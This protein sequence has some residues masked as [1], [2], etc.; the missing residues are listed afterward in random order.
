MTDIASK[1]A[2]ALTILAGFE[3][4][5]GRANISDAGEARM[6]ACLTL[7][8]FEQFRSAMCLIDNGLGTHAAGPIRS[9]LEGVADLVNLAK[10]PNYLSQ[11]HYD[12]ARSNVALYDDA[13]GLENVPPHISEFLREKRD[14]DEPVRKELREAGVG[15]LYVEERLKLAKLGDAYVQYRIL[16][17]MVHTSVTSLMAR[18]VGRGRLTE[19]AY[20]AAPEEP[21]LGML[22]LI[23]ADLLMRAGSEMHN[24]SDL[25]EA[26]VNAVGEEVKKAWIAAD[27][28]YVQA[29]AEDATTDKP[30]EPAQ[31]A[32]PAADR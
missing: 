22:L 19:L 14:R 1:R 30:A 16:C 24:F 23:A 32:A 9:M 25:T 11:L 15:K 20:C 27:P 2:A 31:P 21:V 8:I 6:C 12:D 28:D 4:L 26:E 7:T 10:D 17:S 3:D 18:H 13:M 29:A 5:L